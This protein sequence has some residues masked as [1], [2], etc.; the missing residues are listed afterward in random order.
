[1]RG[2]LLA[3]S[4]IL[5][6]V[7]V[8][9][10]EGTTSAQIAA[11]LNAESATET[12][13]GFRQKDGFEATIIHNNVTGKP[14]WYAANLAPGDEDIAADEHS[15]CK[16]LTKEERLMVDV[17]TLVG[18]AADLLNSGEARDAH[19][20]L[21]SA[22]L[23]HKL[24]GSPQDDGYMWF[25]SVLAGVQ[26]ALGFTHAGAT[27]DA[28]AMAICLRLHGADEPTTV[29]ISNNHAENLLLA[30]EYGEAFALIE[31][32]MEKLDAFIAAGT[33]NIEWLKQVRADAQT[34]FEKILAATGSIATS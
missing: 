27:S 11:A 34:I 18:R 12:C 21:S 4:K 15:C 25:L 2:K 3:V 26:Y 7:L 5:R 16:P 20:L 10:P 31:A 6:S 23:L 22:K 19:R 8:D 30:K 14:F 33:G 32:G 24:A 1:M 28:E 17:R 29:V 13:G 9:L